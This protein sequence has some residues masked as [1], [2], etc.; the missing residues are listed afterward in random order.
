[1]I[2]LISKNI[3]F[4][5]THFYIGVGSVV[6]AQSPDSKAVQWDRG[7]R[8]GGAIIPL[9]QRNV[10]L[11]DLEPNPPPPPLKIQNSQADFSC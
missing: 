11:L 2:I 4:C 8:G 7:R 5:R 1:M 9:K 10:V 3:Y 6:V